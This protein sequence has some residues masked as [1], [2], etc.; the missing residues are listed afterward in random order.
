[1]VVNKHTWEDTGQPPLELPHRILCCPDSNAL[2]TLKK[3]T[4]TFG[5]GNRQAE[6]DV[7]IAKAFT[8]SLL[9][10]QMISNLQL[11]QCISSI[12]PTTE[13]RLKMNS[14]RSF[15]DQES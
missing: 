11:I 7:Y 12:E 8:R 2:V 14:N 9:G 3:F 5:L 4:G 1:M 15:V 10:Q 6:S 13:L